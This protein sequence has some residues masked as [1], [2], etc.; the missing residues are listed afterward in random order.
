LNSRCRP[1]DQRRRRRQAHRSWPVA[2]DGAGVV[3]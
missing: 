3:L 2:A 1:A